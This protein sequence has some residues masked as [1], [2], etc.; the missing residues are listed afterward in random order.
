MLSEIIRGTKTTLPANAKGQRMWY[1]YRY[2]PVMNMYVSRIDDAFGY[3][4]EA[5][6]FDYRY[7]M[8]L[9]RTDLNRL[10]YETDLDNLG[11]IKAVRGPNE[12]AT[13]VPYIIAF[14]YQPKAT[15]GTNGITAPAY[16]VTKHYDIQPPNDDMET[17]TFV[18]GFGRLT[19]INY[20]DYPENNVKYHYGG[21]NS[22]YNRI[23]RLL[24]SRTLHTQQHTLNDGH[25]KTTIT[26]GAHSVDDKHRSPRNVHHRKEH[27]I[28]CSQRPVG[29][30]QGTLQAGRVLPPD[31]ERIQN[32]RVVSR[33]RIGGRRRNLRNELKN[34]GFAVVAA[35]YRLFPRA[36]NP[37]YTQ[38]AAAAVAWTFKHIAEY[39]GDPNQIYVGG[40]SAGGY[41][42][43]MLA[44]DKR[45]LEAEG[46]DA[47]RVK[48]YFPV[49][50]QCA[51]HYTIR[52]E[53]KISFTLPIVDDYAPL[54]HARKL[55][56][57]LV[58]I[59]GDRKLEQ[60]SRYEENLYLKS[61]LE[62]VGNPFI[63]IHE[64]SGFDHGS[65]LA[66]ACEL[67]KGYMRK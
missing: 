60:M 46:I 42:T 57:Q 1:T 20:P 26:T 45:Y 33:R 9:R 25:E 11:R 22:S 49:S 12:L 37:E 4:S 39:G 18:D 5:G 65:V 53:R 61:V 63:P 34:A 31:E 36:K 29:L 51:T 17:V 59:T 54:N 58:L 8:A 7:G 28:R 14:D 44:L 62:G 15:F 40:H 19:A 23:G 43:L 66:P 21:I 24:A 64:L 10:N 6:N 67:I 56:T 32:H 50:G 16:A 48:G 3:S 52:K 38:D 55:H 47:D 13:G 2:E 35:T 30:P 27:R 41:L